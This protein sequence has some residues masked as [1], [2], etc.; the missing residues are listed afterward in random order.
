MMV[1]CSKSLSYAHPVGAL[2]R[3]RAKITSKEGGTSFV[4]S[5]YKWPVSIVS[6]EEA[7]RYIQNN[8]P[9]SW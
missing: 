1:E 5:S 8:S 9:W 4:Y 3:I 2:F 7:A 6:P